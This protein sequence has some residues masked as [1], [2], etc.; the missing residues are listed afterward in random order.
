MPR[1]VPT[2]TPNQH[3]PWLLEVNSGPDLSLFGA[4]LRPLGLGMLRELLQ[5]LE[6]EAIFGSTPPPHPEEGGPE[7][8]IEG[9]LPLP[10]SGAVIGGFECVYVQRCAEPAGE[11][12]RFKRLMSLAGRFAHSLHQ[13]SGAPVRG[14]QGLVRQGQARITA[15]QA[16]ATVQQPT[17]T[18][19]GSAVVDGTHGGET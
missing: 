11:L 18:G 6:A 4:R 2:P 3:K 10:S 1:H 16:A 19:G 15:A 14:V 7:G 17:G 9:G 12:A 8:G 5:V 13:T